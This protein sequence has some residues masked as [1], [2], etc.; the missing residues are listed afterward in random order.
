ME[1]FALTRE[2]IGKSEVT[3]GTPALLER[4]SKAEEEIQL[5]YLAKHSGSPAVTVD[6]RAA[7]AKAERSGLA[8]R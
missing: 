7:I 6:R 3:A 2:A 5:A 4:L 1:D 8:V